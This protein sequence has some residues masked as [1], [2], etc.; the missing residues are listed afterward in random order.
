M[1]TPKK[2]PSDH[3]PKG[4]PSKYDSSMCS[5]VISCMSK[6]YIVEEVCSEIG[7]HRDTFFE[8]VKIY[9][10]F[11][12]CYKKGKAGFIAFWA[13]IYKKVMMGV[14]LN[15]PKKTAP[16]T[17]AGQKKGATQKDKEKEEKAVEL[18]KSNPAMM[19]FYMKA[20]CGW[21]E[22]VNNNNKVKVYDISD[23]A[24]KRMVCIF[25]EMLSSEVKPTNIL[26]QK[27]LNNND[28]SEDVG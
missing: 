23:D 27:S 15:P 18:G 8:W 3:L 19:I 7:I 17:K 12:D 1:A 11:S 24:K 13:K 16:K 9:P 21:R 25:N 10:D 4:R 22:T 26:E 28:E 2:E 20:H 5:T 14:P 6:G